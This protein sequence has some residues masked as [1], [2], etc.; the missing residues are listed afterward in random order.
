MRRIVRIHVHVYIYVH[1][2]TYVHVYIYTHM[3]L[4]THIYRR[5][6]R[7]V[8]VYI[9]INTLHIYVYACKCIH[10]P[11]YADRKKPPP[12]GGFILTMFPDQKPCVS[13][14]RSKNL[15]QITHTHTHTHSSKNLVHIFSGGSSYTR[16]LM[17]EHSK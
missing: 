11:A 6:S 10:V 1:V 16:F 14:P 5:L 13:G 17:R 7:Q 8:R 2:Y 3:C 9:Y 12:Q 4:Y 15:V